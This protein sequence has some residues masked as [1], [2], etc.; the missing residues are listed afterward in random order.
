MLQFN[1]AVKKKPNIWEIEREK[2]VLPP[3]V[4]TRE[5][6][7][8]KRQSDDIESVLVNNPVLVNEKVKK[9]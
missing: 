8:L 4:T 9:G 3:K 5:E 6:R 1:E 2:I 7:L